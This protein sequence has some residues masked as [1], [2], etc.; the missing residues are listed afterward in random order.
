MKEL[1]LKALAIVTAVVGLCIMSFQYGRSTAKVPAQI[2]HTVYEDRI[3]E[4][5]KIVYVKVN[6]KEDTKTTTTKPD[7]TVIVEEKKSDSKTEISSE[8]KEKTKEKTVTVDKTNSVKQWRGTVMAGLPL[9]D[10]RDM[11]PVYGGGLEHRVIGP[12]SAGGW[13]LHTKEKY[14]G[15]SVSM[16]F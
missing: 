6:V 9:P 14:I 12:F 8:E 13:Y 1:A 16:E 4:K 7:G 15:A 10:W 2:E 3:V 11:K 5:E